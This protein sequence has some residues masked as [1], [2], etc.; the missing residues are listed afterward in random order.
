MYTDIHTHIQWHTREYI[1]AHVNIYIYI[2]ISWYMYA[3][4]LNHS[5]RSDDIY[6]E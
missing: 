2:Y 4:Y 1:F 6:N 3:V 5:D